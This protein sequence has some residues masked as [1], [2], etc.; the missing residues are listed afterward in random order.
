MNDPWR[1]G[2]NEAVA[3]ILYRVIENRSA[4]DTDVLPDA[5]RAAITSDSE[6]RTTDWVQYLMTEDLLP[7]FS[8]GGGRD[9]EGSRYAHYHVADN[10]V[11][12]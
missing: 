5:V 12:H 1:L 4:T 11:G 3:S 2:D 7:G 9:S 6:E 10:G 8:Q